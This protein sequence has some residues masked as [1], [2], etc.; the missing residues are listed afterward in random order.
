MLTSS[1][2]IINWSWVD[3]S[4]ASGSVV[5]ERLIEFFSKEGCVAGWLEE[6]EVTDRGTTSWS[7]VEFWL[8]DWWLGKTTGSLGEAFNW[9][10]GSRNVTGW[11]YWG[12]GVGG[13][14]FSMLFMTSKLESFWLFSPPGSVTQGPYIIIT[15]T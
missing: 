3:R 7:E 10:V 14:G 15:M 9:R 1:V 12:F 8:V 13:T 2:S 6:E 5:L 4:A 11:L